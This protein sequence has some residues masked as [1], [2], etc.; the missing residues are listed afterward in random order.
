LGASNL[1][2]E[3]VAGESN[4][5]TW[6]DRSYD[7]TLFR[8]ERRIKGQAVYGALA[9]T[10]PNRNYFLD[11]TSSVGV[12]YEYQVIAYNGIDLLPSNLASATPFSSSLPLKTPDFVIRNEPTE[13][14]VSFD[15]E[16]GATYQVEQSGD[17][18]NWNFVNRFSSNQSEAVRVPLE[19]GTSTP[20]FTRLQSSRFDVP[21]SVIG[22]LG[23]FEL[24]VNENGSIFDLTTFGATPNDDTDDDAGALQFAL[25][26]LNPGDTLTIPSGIFH[27]KTSINLPSGITL[28]GQGKDITQFTTLGISTAFKI[29]EGKTDITLSDFGIGGSDSALAYGVFIGETNGTNAERIWIDSLEIQTFSRRGIQVRNANHVKIDRC[30]IHHATNLGGGGFGYAIALND[31]NNHNNWVTQCEIGP[32]IRHGVLIQFSA[33]NNLVELNTCIGTT[34]DAYDLHGEDE[35][36]NELRF[37]LAYWREDSN[38]EGTPAGFGIGNT[39][40]THDNSGPNNWVHHNEVYGYEIGLEIIQRSHVQYVDGNN[41]HNNAT[42]IKIHDSGGNRIHIR[43]NAIA[44]NV[45]GISATRSANIQIEYNK[46]NRNELGISLTPDIDDYSIRFNDLSGNATGKNVGS[47]SGVFEGNLE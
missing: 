15:A 34:E 36:A 3:G 28:R 33:H 35:Y 9:V 13:I 22:L 26:Q 18:A 10:E 7:E 17:L 40:A 42:G 21:H 16:E 44:D 43:G 37:N 25:S 39:G 30:A 45:T 6:S 23:D 5:L 38:I 12:E 31:S 24:P 1:V 2:A 19:I 27:I 29:D 41:F 4:L 8:I 14:F 11:T 20:S 46:I 47:D 32:V